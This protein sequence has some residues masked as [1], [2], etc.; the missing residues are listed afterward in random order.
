MEN[1]IYC[2]PIYKCGICGTEHDSVLKRANCELSCTKKQ[3]EEE[4]KIQETK[5]QQEREKRYMEVVEA[6]K[7]A[8]ELRKKYV[9]DY[10]GF[11]ST[12]TYSDLIDAI[13][14]NPNWY[15]WF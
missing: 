9:E 5:L 15:A 3:Q 6:Q 12:T 10:C 14:D 2:K 1:N 8:D 11:T 7:K 13:F 4:K